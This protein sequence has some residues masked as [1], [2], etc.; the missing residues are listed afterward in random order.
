MGRVG[1][2]CINRGFHKTRL[3]YESTDRPCQCGAIITNEDV[4]ATGVWRN[5]D[6]SGRA[7][8][9]SVNDQCCCCQFVDSPGG[10]PRDPWRG[11]CACAQIMIAQNLQSGERADAREWT[12]EREKERAKC[13]AGR[14]REGERALAQGRGRTS[15]V[16]RAGGNAIM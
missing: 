6:D 13:K 9:G 3:R 5:V 15:V 10:D 16:G 8:M 2:A 14:S 4:E 1:H 11:A 12:R 7:K